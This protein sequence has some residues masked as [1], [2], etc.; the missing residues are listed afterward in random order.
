MVF[1]HLILMQL[2][3]SDRFKCSNNK[4]KLCMDFFKTIFTRH[5]A[6]YLSIL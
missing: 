2:W 6:T 4:K 1:Q 5:S 3:N